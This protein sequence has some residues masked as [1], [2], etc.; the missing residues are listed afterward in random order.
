MPK[1]KNRSPR[2]Q[3][4][5]LPHLG[6]EKD[7]FERTHDPVSGDYGLRQT[8]KRICESITFLGYEEKEVDEETLEQPEIKSALDREDGLMVVEEQE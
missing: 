2:M 7:H 6:E 1:L 4:F 3:V 8:T 5:N